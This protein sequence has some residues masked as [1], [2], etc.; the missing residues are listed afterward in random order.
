MLFT[1][2]GQERVRNHKYLE[3]FHINN[4]QSKMQKEL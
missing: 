3:L 4:I 2:F 1:I